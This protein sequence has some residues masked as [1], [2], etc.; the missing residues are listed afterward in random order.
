MLHHRGELEYSNFGGM[1][2][3]YACLL[4]TSDSRWGLEVVDRKLDLLLGELRRYGVP[5]AGVQK[6]R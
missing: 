1:L 4:E 5:V 6:S 2:R 3:R